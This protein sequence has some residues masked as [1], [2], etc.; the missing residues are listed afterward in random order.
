MVQAGPEN[1]RVQGWVGR[2]TG[3]RLANQTEGNE[4]LVTM[5][6]ARAILYLDW[7]PVASQTVFLAPLVHIL[8]GPLTTDTLFPPFCDIS[9]PVDIGAFRG[10]LSLL[11]RFL[12]L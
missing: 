5:H 10:C 1:F 6:L 3:I 4:A 7:T 11:N 2:R 8:K 9:T 12:L